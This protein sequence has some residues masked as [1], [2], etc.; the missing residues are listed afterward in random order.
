VPGGDLTGE[1][2]SG[3]WSQHATCADVAAR[4]VPWTA[5]YLRRALAVDGTCALAAGPLAFQLRGYV[6]T[7]TAACLA[8]NGHDVWG[9]DIDAAK[10]DDV[11]TGRSP[12]AEP[13]L[14]TL[15]AG[16]VSDG[17]LHATMSCADAD[18]AS[19]ATLTTTT[20]CPLTRRAGRHSACAVPAGQFRVPLASPASG[21]TLRCPARR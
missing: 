1:K 2:C 7:V 11:R 6:G 15:V 8:T 3:G 10:V 20:A 12:V 18:P 21:F 19:R 4:S 5:S 14:N 16:A 9:V 13:G 17:T